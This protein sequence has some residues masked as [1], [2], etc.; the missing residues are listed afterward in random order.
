MV[1]DFWASLIM[2]I[3]ALSLFSFL[4]R[5]ASD[6]ARVT[7]PPVSPSNRPAQ[8]LGKIAACLGSKEMNGKR[9]GIDSRCHTIFTDGRG[10][11][12]LLPLP[13]NGGNNRAKLGR[14][15]IAILPR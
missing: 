13:V 15:G 2:R 1:P 10:V 11:A 4:P 5:A 6:I 9:I 14:K 3:A 12:A 7:S 8:G